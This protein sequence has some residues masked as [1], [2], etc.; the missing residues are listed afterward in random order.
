MIP[1]SRRD[2]GFLGSFDLRHQRSGQSRS[3][4]SIFRPAGLFDF[5]CQVRRIDESD[6]S[7]ASLQRVRG[8]A[9]R[10]EIALRQRVPEPVGKLGVFLKENRDE[11]LQ[12][13]LVTL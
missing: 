1:P 10:S 11:F 2:H 9:H 3:S 7:Q 5:Q 13:G 4:G 6:V 12:Q 8:L